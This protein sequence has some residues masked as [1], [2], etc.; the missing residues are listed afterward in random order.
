MKWKPQPR[1]V[2]EHCSLANSITDTAPI[3]LFRESKLADS[4]AYKTK[5]HA[6]A[7]FN[8]ASREADA[9]AYKTK[10]T[11]EAAYIAATKD[12]EAILVRQTKEAE[13]LSRKWPTH[14]P[15]WRKPSVVLKA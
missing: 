9:Q 12:A 15:R 10:V 8:A 6:E 5:I 13:G 14:M 11:A 1:L 2:S 4:H 3:D 7:S